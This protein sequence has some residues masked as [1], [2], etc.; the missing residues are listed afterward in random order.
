MVA[1]D[2]E[3]QDA[4][5]V[6]VVSESRE[7]ILKN[8]LGIHIMLS[9]ARICGS[10]RR[11]HRDMRFNIDGSTAASI[12]ESSIAKLFPLNAQFY[13]ARCK[14]LPLTEHIRFHTWGGRQS[15]TRELMTP[16]QMHI[17]TSP[18][19]INEHKVT[20]LYIMG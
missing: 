9:E 11:R 2:R 16:Q 7:V 13:K 8:V 3:I 10:F 18:Y 17:V 5:H 6:V 4:A 14:G 12:V 15:H 20:C 19:H 1:K